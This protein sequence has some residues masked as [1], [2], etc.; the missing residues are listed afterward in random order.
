M[1]KSK[2]VIFTFDERSYTTLVKMTEFG[3]FKSMADCVRNSLQLNRAIETEKFDGYTEV[4]VRNPK[5]GKEK[6][7]VTSRQK[8]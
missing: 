5:T 4:I 2:R 8:R 6:V 7:L 1:S 3:K